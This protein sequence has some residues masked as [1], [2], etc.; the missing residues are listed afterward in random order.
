MRVITTCWG[1]LILADA[2]FVEE[3]DK[4]A[5][6]TEKN[7]VDIPWI[8]YM[9]LLSVNSNLLNYSSLSNRDKN[10]KRK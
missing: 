5:N 8:F 3:I 1:I 6:E 4:N 7:P 2:R 10:D 9:A